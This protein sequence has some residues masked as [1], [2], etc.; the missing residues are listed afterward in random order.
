MKRTKKHQNQFDSKQEKLNKRNSKF[1][2]N[3]NDEYEVDDD[4]TDDDEIVLSRSSYQEEDDDIYGDIFEE[5]EKKISQK[6]KNTIDDENDTPK[7]RGRKSKT[8]TKYYVN[9]AELATEIRK[10]QTTRCYQ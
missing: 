3:E 2:K 4:E 8:D 1:S 10:Y 7:R 9:N 6:C 5:D